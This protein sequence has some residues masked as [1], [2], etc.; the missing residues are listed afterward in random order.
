MNEMKKKTKKSIGQR[1]IESLQETVESLRSGASLED[2]FTCH[3]VDVDVKP[4]VYDA[5]MV[6]NTRQLLKASQTVFAKLLGV[7]G[8]NTTIM[9]AGGQG[10]R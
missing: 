8:A 5:Q 2:T 4:F 6:K 3:R 1:I 9:G 7:V 10:S